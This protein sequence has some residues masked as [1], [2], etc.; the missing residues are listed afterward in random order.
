MEKRLQTK[1]DQIAKYFILFL[2]SWAKERMM[3]Y[4]YLN[5]MVPHFSNVMR[6]KMQV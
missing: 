2:F 1:W 3:Q 5:I 4:E 6:N